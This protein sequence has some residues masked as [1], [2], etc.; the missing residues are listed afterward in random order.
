MI[1]EINRIIDSVIRKVRDVT[2][3]FDSFS[4]LTKKKSPDA[5]DAPMVRISSRI[6]S[7]NSMAAVM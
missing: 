1:S 2:S 7:L 5:R 6:N 4:S 3:R